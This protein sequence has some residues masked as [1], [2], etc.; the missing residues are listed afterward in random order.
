MRFSRPVRDRSQQ[1]VTIGSQQLLN[2]AR[3][4]VIFSYGLFTIAAQ[5]LLFREFITT[6]EGNDISVGTFFASWFLWVS[7][8]ALLVYKRKNFA[9]KLLA[10]IEFLFLAYLPAFVLQAMLIIYAR[11]LA[12]IPILRFLCGTG[13]GG[14]EPYARLTV[15]AILLLSIVVNVPVSTITGMLFPI[16]CRWVRRGFGLAVS[17]VYII[18]AA[19]SFFGGLAATL[20]LGLGVSSAS[21][22]L[23]LALI[24]SA[25]VFFVQTT[26]TLTQYSSGVTGHGAQRAFCG[27]FFLVSL[28]FLLCLTLGADTAVMQRV[29]TVK[30]NRLLP[31]G[32]LEGSFQTPQAEYLY[33]TYR[34]QWVAVR[35][36]SV[37]EALPNESVA[38]RVAAITLCQKPDAKSVLVVGSTLSL[39]RQLL[40][41]PQIERV[42]WAHSDSEYVQEVNKFIPVEF[43]I[44]DERFDQPSGDIRLMLADRK[45]YYDIAIVDLPEATSSVLNRYYTLEFYRDVK[46]SLRPHGLLAVRIAGGENIMGTELINL[47][48]STKL[49]L[50]KVVHQPI[51]LVPG[52]DTWLLASDSENVTGEP[53]ILR[54]RFA[55]IQG[56]ANIYPPEGLLSVYLPDRADKALEAYSTADLPEALLVNRDARPLTHL[57]N[58]LL[59]AKQSGAPLTRFVKLL[60]LAGPLAFLI[61]CLVLVI[62][63]VVYVLSSVARRLTHVSRATGHEPRATS[64]DSSFLVFSSGWVGIGVVIILMYLYQ[65]HFGSLYLYIGV[66]S[67]LFMVGLTMGAI[68][69]RRILR[70]AVLKEQGREPAQQTVLF[71]VVF[72]HALILAAAAYWSTG[73]W[74]AAGGT[75]ASILAPSHLT[76]AVAFVLCGLC[77]GCY[78]PLAA[79]QLAE[80]GFEA[81]AAGSKLETA[82]HIGA[83][84]GGL[85]TSLALLPVL[86]AKLALFVFIVL[87]LAN[88]PPAALKLYKPQKILTLDTTAFRLRRAAFI[89]FAVGTSV[90]LCSNLLATAAARLRP[91]LPRYAAQAL[92][93]ELRLRQESAVLADSARSISYFSV[94]DPNDKLTG[95]IFSSQDLAPEVRG[96]GGKMNLAIYLDD[97]NG[98]LIDLHIIRSNETPAYLDMLSRPDA[99]NTTWLDALKGHHL[100]QPEPFADLDAV[101]GA[102]VSSKAILSA[103]ETSGHRFATQVLARAIQPGSIQQKHTAGYLRDTPGLYLITASLLT[104]VVIYVGGFWTRLAVLLFNVV[105]GG[106]VLNAQYSSEQ[107]ATALSLHAPAPGLTGAFLLVVG[108]PVLAMLFGNIYCGYICPF[109]AAQELLGYL[110]PK[111]FKQ[112][113]SIET[114][115][116]AR[117][118]KYVVLFILIAVFFVS[119]DRTTLGSDPLI[120]VFARQFWQLT[121]LMIAV[122]ALIGS[123]FYVRFWCRYLC[124]VGAFLSLFN[125]IVILKRYVP[126][127]RF[128]KCDFGL[129]AGDHLDCIYC[130]RCRY[131]AKVAVKKE[132]SPKP[133][134]APAWLRARYFVAWVLVI[135]ILVSA[136]S[137]KRFSQVTAVSSDYSAAF[138]SS[139][140]QPRDVDMQRVRRMIQ[141][142]RLSDREAEFYK[143][144]E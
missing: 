139:G 115:Q 29:R 60:A 45:Q 31:A 63:R 131:Q 2:G 109:G 112:P 14:I 94:S 120:S 134:Y 74:T 7:I 88:L 116:K 35:E 92:A 11:E 143:K 50:E 108:V 77:S 33:G 10:N 64:F 46:E 65:T 72:V 71:G 53:G 66:I 138:V 73:E 59:A 13:P 79:A 8:G 69:I 44:S 99:N 6:F 47:G 137:L 52:D 27:L 80:S 129:T 119:R 118:V 122:T 126:A 105:V 20:L 12:G 49:T 5:A 96:F 17:R 9:E 15:R 102:T 130:D 36:G 83:S 41:L 30:W 101:T 76:F 28:S 91:A 70:L 18:E 54:D 67:S 21:L 68:I 3:A 135:A 40:S 107:I 136:V 132:P 106:I 56:A 97:P 144:V 127:K 42:T 39:C 62:L 98:K 84:V 93:G 4:F 58:L 123:L 114:M 78:F 95:Y 133:A 61:P 23:M 142:K 37:C 81:G 104:L 48:A 103:L 124:P 128:G 38:G 57:Y 55:A 117:F 111:R 86:G 26:K 16:A 43:R 24:L 125:K 22:F 32:K 90:V 25:S 110:I 1:Q 75:M 140:G 19:G 113:P 121:L 51:V 82:D 100:F 34:D 85:V 89:L 87:I 141:Q